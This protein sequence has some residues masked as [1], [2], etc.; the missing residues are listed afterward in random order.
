MLYALAAS[1]AQAL[2]EG[3]MPTIESAWDYVQGEELQRTFVEVL[4]KHTH[5][6]QQQFAD[7]PQNE[8]KLIEDLKSCKQACAQDFK[9]SLMGGA[10]LLNSAKGL[11]Y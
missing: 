5:L 7:L 3:K 6:I 11:E 10:E 8:T 1:Y 2:N 4:S 9:S